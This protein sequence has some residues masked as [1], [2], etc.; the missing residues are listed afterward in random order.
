MWFQRHTFVRRF[1]RFDE[2]HA[3]RLSQ[4]TII[5]WRILVNRLVKATAD[6]SLLFEPGDVDGILFSVPGEFRFCICDCPDVLMQTYSE[7]RWS[8]SVKIIHR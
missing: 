4:P 8:Q 2:I 6:S 5:L 1:D 7:S 3:N